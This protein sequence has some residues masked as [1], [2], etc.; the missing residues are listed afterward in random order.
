MIFF[1]HSVHGS[2]ISS[3]PKQEKPLT[4]LRILPRNLVAQCRG[5]LCGP[6][7]SG[8]GFFEDSPD[9][10]LQAARYLIATAKPPAKKTE[11]SR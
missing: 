5:L 1:L 7:N 3:R 10:L 2:S 9:L 8:L 4:T 6:C 11:H